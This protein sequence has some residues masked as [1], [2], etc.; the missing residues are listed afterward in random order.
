MIDE[1]DLPK[2]IRTLRIML[3]HALMNEKE[4]ERIGKKHLKAKYY[5]RVITL[6]EVL[7]M[8]GDVS[9]LETT[10]EYFEQYAYLLGEEEK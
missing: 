8:V 3:E 4:C 6:M 10:S 9:V 1:H 5:E 2:L 7:N